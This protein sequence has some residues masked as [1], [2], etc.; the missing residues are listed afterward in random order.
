MNNAFPNP[1]SIL[2]AISV[3][4]P[5]GD[6]TAVC[7]LLVVSALRAGA[8]P[9][10]LLAVAVAV[11]CARFRLFILVCVVMLSSFSGVLV[12]QF[13]TSGRSGH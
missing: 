13:T 10:V 8:W 12:A 2:A 11:A 4:G 5:A 3:T 9:T 7:S 6:G 1:T